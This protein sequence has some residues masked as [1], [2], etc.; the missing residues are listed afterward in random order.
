MTAYFP[1]P[2]NIFIPELNDKIEGSI[3][4]L[5]CPNNRLKKLFF[6]RKYTD[7][8]YL[9]IYLFAKNNWHLLEI[10]RCEPY[11]FIEIKR[12]E[13]K[14]EDTQM[15]VAIPKKLND[16]KNITS[17]LQEPDSLRVDNSGVA[18]RVSLNF[19]IS[20]SITTYQGEYPFL[21]SS[22]QK[23][24]LFSF[25]TL[26]DIKYLNKKSFLI[27]MNISQN[28]NKFEKIKLKLFDPNKKNKFKLIYAYRNSFNI[29]DIDKYEVIFGKR[30]TTFLT[31]EYCSFIPMIL[32]IDLR[33]NQLSVEH[34]H[35]PSEYF[36]G[37][38]KLE[39]VNLLKKQWLN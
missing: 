37:S 6:N 33:T 27:L 9:G 21:M 14:V 23:G 8:I 20:N 28:N 12:N 10:K 3:T 7:V 11:Q 31:S 15:V 22:L 5:N 30:L 17:K 19:S 34:N 29:L 32:S 38:R 24:S 18:Q 36:F 1:L 39:A 35:P 13:L 16:F 25:D 2:P 26:K 4:F